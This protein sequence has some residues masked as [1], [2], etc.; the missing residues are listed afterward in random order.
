MISIIIPVYNG[1]EY[2]QKCLDSIFA[3]DADLSDLE[4]L[5]IN[6]GSKDSSSALLHAYAETHPR[7]RVID[8]ENAGAAQARQHGLKL[9]KGDWI[10][11][12]DVDDTV[13]PELYQRMAKK[14]AETDSDIVFC[15]YI[16]EHPSKSRPVKNRFDKGQTFPLTGTQ[17]ISYLHR[18]QAVFPFP[19]NKLYRAELLR[20]VE[21]PEG[22]LVGEDYNMLLQLFSMTDRIDY[23]PLCGNHY[24][25]VENSVSR[26]GFTEITVR[27]YAHFQQSYAWVC[28][29]YPSM[30]KEAAH[31]LMIEYMAMIVAMGRNRTYDKPMIRQIKAFVRSHLF[32]FLGASYV[33]FLMKGGALAL[34]ISYRL[35]IGT[36]RL[37]AKLR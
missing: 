6:D 29:Q 8:Q 19:W 11:F 7:L 37:T 23:L 33:S 35:L 18:R 10:A 16:E 14:A 21:F 12:L 3:P 13:E 9:A 27:S 36:Y 34:M 2:V 28:E 17:A 22:T 5:A 25:I 26:R 31:Y 4:V 15:D 30:K 32:G 24:S 20:R 1:E